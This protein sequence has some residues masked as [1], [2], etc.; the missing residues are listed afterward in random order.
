VNVLDENF[1]VDQVL[2]LRRWRI[3]CRRLAEDL[4]AP[5]IKDPDV[6]P[7][8]RSTPSPTFL[9]H[10]RDNFRRCLVWLD[11]HD[12]F[13][14]EFT[15]RFLKHPRFNTSA[16]RMGTVVHVHTDGIQFWEWGRGDMQFESWSSKRFPRRGSAGE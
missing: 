15:R 8:L 2:Q 16:R 4:A 12:W 5:G 13:A 7:L 3:H 14:V 6:M 9:T 10:D 1:R 11:V